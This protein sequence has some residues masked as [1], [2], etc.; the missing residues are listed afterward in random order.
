MLRSGHGPPI[1]CVSSVGLKG[2]LL[3]VETFVEFAIAK[4]LSG[5][6]GTGWKQLLHVIDSKGQ[7]N[8][9]LLREPEL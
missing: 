4:K 1:L 8:D 9:S 2:R 7:K 6:T 5:L 3:T